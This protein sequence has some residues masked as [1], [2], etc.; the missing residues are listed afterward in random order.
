M[1]QL[2]FDPSSVEGS[3]NFD[4]IPAGTYEAMIFGAE[5]K[6]SKA[7]NKYLEIQFQITQE[8]Y[9]NRRIFDNINLFH[10]TEKV[11]NIAEIQ[12]RDICEAIELKGAL[13]DTSQ[14]EGKTLMVSLKI[15][16]SDQY[17]DKNRVKGYSPVHHG[18]A[19]PASQQYNQPAQPAGV[20]QAGGPPW[21]R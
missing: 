21:K 11:R 19:P 2:N 5:L 16:K 6:E 15:E 9:A 18:Y 20:S 17:G 14:L 4:V 1:V 13:T 10:P 8:P 12:L 7:G 3:N